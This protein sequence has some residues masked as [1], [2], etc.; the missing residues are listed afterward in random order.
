MVRWNQ[1]VQSP[2]IL[3]AAKACFR[4]D[5]FDAAMGTTARRVPQLDWPTDKIGAFAGPPFDDENI[6][7]YV[8]ALTARIK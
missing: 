8:A 1:A 6:G 4:P 3:A 2:E 7:A 5:L